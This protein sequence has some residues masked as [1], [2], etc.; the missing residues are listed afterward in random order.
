MN[1]FS[2]FLPENK[3]IRSMHKARPK[4]LHIEPENI[5]NSNLASE[6]NIHKTILNKKCKEFY[7]NLISF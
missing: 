6:L 4:H 5:L 7:T 1:Y 3:Y 2:F